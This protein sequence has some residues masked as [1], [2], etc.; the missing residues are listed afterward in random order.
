MARAFLIYNPAAARTRPGIVQAIGNV[1]SSA[2]WSLQAAGTECPDDAVG[3]A[4]QGLAW[5]CDAIA[6]YGGDGT[7]HAVAGEVG[8]RVPLGLI[9]GGTGNLLAGNLRLPRN[10]IKAARVIV[11]GVARPFDMGRLTCSSATRHFT[12]A[13]GAGFDAELMAGATGEAKRRWGMGAYVATAWD[14]IGQLRTVGHRLTVDGQ[15]WEAE[16]ASVLVA[17]CAEIIPPFLRLREGIRP[18]DGVLDVVVLN[19]RGL[20][21][22]AGVLWRLASGRTNGTSAVQFARCRSC[23]VETDEVRPVQL[24]GD[25]FGSTPFAVD[26]VPAGMRV[27]VP[28]E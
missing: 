28:R 6:V 16:A 27:M 5:G 17:N 13:C 15:T 7:V 1:F 4:R 18:D 8:D 23:T 11:G 20:V 19:A 22:T 26:V 10:P 24:D 14:L 3:L 9:P 12:V 21:D 2:G 25:A